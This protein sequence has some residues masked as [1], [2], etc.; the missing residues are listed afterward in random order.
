MRG[1][2]LSQG[3]ERTLDLKMEEILIDEEKRNGKMGE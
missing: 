1:K 3:G 2:H